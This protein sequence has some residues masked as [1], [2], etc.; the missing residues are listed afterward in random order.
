MVYVSTV[1]WE[2]NREEKEDKLKKGGKEETTA[3]ICSCPQRVLREMGVTPIL[4]PGEKKDK[5]GK[6]GKNQRL[7]ELKV[8][9]EGAFGERVSHSNWLSMKGEI[10]KGQG[11]EDE[12]AS[13]RTEDD[14]L[15]KT[16]GRRHPTSTFGS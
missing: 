12:E 8:S 1:E 13:H 6:T 3:G 15:K 4:G 11:Q 10:E 14:L 5:G 2:G 9:L 16:L 7:A